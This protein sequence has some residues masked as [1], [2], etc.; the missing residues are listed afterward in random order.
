MYQ[1]NRRFAQ[2]VLATASTTLAIGSAHALNPQPLPPK[3][4]Y[5]SGAFAW[6]ALNPQPLPPRVTSASS[7]VAWRALNPQPLP[8]K[9]VPILRSSSTLSI[10]AIIGSSR[11][12]F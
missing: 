2:A 9:P 11:I 7:R 8:P 6:R 4:L 5:S 12:R 10:N 3:M 1:L